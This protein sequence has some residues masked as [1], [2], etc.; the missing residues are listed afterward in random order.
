MIA[1]GLTVVLVVLVTAVPAGLA[2]EGPPPSLVAACG[3]F[4]GVTAQSSWLTTSDGVRLYTIEAGDGPVAAVLA[5]QGRSDLCEELPYAKTLLA[6]GLRVLAFDFRGNGHSDNPA[7]NR[8]SLGRDLAA[9]VARARAGGAKH[10]FLIGA[11]M[12]GAAV[13]Q[14]TARLAVDGRI[15]LSGTRLWAGFGIND[16]AGVHALRAPFLYL[17]STNDWR[18]PKSEARAILRSVGSRDKR[19]TLYPGGLHGW[20][21]VQSAPFA[22]RARALILGWIRSRS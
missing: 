9:A 5:H 18:A 10:V 6:A 16:A 14:N 21:L 12:G 3:D 13:V 8:L 11:S 15:S 7:R 4:S 20:Q 1:R 2:D 17:G 22:A 19:I